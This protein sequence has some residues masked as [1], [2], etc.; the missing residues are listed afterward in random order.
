[1]QKWF[2]GLNGLRVVLV[3]KPLAVCLVLVAVSGQ[4]SGQVMANKTKFAD[5]R[6]QSAQAAED[7][8][9]ETTPRESARAHEQVESIRLAKFELDK[10]HLAINGYDPVAYFPEQGGKATV[11]SKKITHTHRGVV[12]RFASKAHR[13]IFKEDPAKYEPAYG[14]WCAYAIAKQGYTKANPKRFLIQGGRLMLFYDGLLGDTYKAWQK[15]GAKPLE[16]GADVFWAD[17]LK[18][19]ASRQ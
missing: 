14:G 4:A 1:M 8:G 7:A 3:W 15:E 9:K 18:K 6:S 19:E 12:Y 11:G 13:E 16:S 2:Q 10:K 5:G 17:E